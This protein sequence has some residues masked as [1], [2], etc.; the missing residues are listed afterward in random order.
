ML[1]VLISVWGW[2]DL[3]AIVRSEGLC[4]WKIPMTPSG[5]EPATFRFVAQYLNHCAY[6]WQPYHLY[7]PIVLKSGRLNLLEPSGPVQVRNGIALP[8]YSL[9]TRLPTHF[10][11]KTQKSYIPW[12]YVVLIFRLFSLLSWRIVNALKFSIIVCACYALILWGSSW[13]ASKKWLVTEA[14]KL[15]SW[16]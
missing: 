10:Q 6:D 13:D 14:V 2:V 3:R 12:K 1:L 4:Q 15:I 7:V 8:F 16:F 5:I 11:S 9:S